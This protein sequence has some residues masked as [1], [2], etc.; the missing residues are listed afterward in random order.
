MSDAFAKWREKRTARRPAATPA[1]TPV[2]EYRSTYLN[3]GWA[4]LLLLLWTPVVLTGL[5][6]MFLNEGALNAIPYSTG[7][8]VLV[9]LLAFASLAL[10]PMLGPAS[11]RHWT[12]WPDAI[13]IRQR[14]CIPLLGV[15][16][17]VRLPFADIAV[18]RKGEMLSGMEMFELQDRRGRRFRL[19]P[20]TIGSGK[21]GRIDH[22][23]FDTF[24]AAIRATIHASGVPV[25]RGEELRM[26]TSGLIGVII[27][28]LI[29]A[30]MGAL[31]VFGVVF[32]LQ[33]EPVGMQALAFGV[34]FGLLFAGLT[35]NRWRKWRASRG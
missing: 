17:H 33:G 31:C 9:M 25:P 29:T 28:S 10:V 24:I 34:P 18:A 13:E 11:R 5:I 20:T 26:P 16:R 30:L 35:R 2:S 6:Y 32:V 22:H 15:Y 3:R 14:P 7:P 12:L 19:L 4:A 8:R 1:T 21:A 23:G 27:L